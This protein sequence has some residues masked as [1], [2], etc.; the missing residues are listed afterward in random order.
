MNQNFTVGFLRGCSALWV[1]VAHCCF[2]G[3]Y[4][5]YVPDPKVAVD[6]FMMVSGFL[7]MYTTDNLHA[8]EPLR[9]KRNWVRFY[10]RRFFRISPGYYASLAIAVVL[11][12]IYV[13]SYQ[14]L[15]KLNH[16][17]YLA[18]LS[19]DFSATNIVLHITYLFGVLPKYA[20]STLLPDWSLSL[21]MQFYLVF[22][23]VYLF[24]K[25]V[26]S[27]AWLIVCGLA[28]LA[29]S[30]VSSATIMKDFTEV[31]LILYQFPFFMIGSLIFFI[32]R[33]EY[34]AL[35]LAASFL[36]TAFCMFAIVLKSHDDVYLLGA[37]CLLFLS[38]TNTSVSLTLNGSRASVP[39]DRIFNNRLFKTLSDLSFSVYL[40]H[41]FVI[42][43][44]GARIEPA[45]YSLGFS[46]KQSVVVIIACVLPITYVAAYLSYKYIEQ[47]GIRLGKFVI[48]KI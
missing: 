5:G 23:L 25:M 44:L 10:L 17:P 12:S 19:A 40:F 29:I 38:S 6:I 35:Q 16:N 46:T 11:S 21:E 14:L 39:I 3:G 41:G 47:P 31:S 42:S 45:L 43:I 48:T 1:V 15:G 2:W 26:K 22:P 37:A 27:S 20:F 7:M 13:P 32:S 24:L 36:V 9:E 34:R 30:Y 33:N 8:K 4:K 28:V 18:G